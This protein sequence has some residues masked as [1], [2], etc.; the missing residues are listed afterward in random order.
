MQQQLVRLML[1][2]STVEK[3]KLC[4]YLQL[5]VL[6][7]Q[8]RTWIYQP[9]LDLDR[10]PPPTNTLENAAG[11]RRRGRVHEACKTARPPARPL[12]TD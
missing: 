10:V 4:C 1:K 8:P 9:L 11:P 12:L 7:L 6:D 2:S 3:I 5:G